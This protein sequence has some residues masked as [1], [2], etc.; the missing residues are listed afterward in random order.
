MPVVSKPKLMDGKLTATVKSSTKLI[1]ARLH[2][3]TGPHADN[4]TR[5]WVTKDLT[6]DGNKLKGK[7]PPKEATAWYVDVTDSRKLL[8]SSEVIVR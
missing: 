3:T 2:Y 5:R 7:S 4:K 6:I 1:T 8:V